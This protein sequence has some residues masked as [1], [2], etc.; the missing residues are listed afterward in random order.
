MGIERTEEKS[1]GFEEDR[2]PAMPWQSGLKTLTASSEPWER[3][4]SLKAT[5]L[6]PVVI[7]H[8]SVTPTRLP[9]IRGF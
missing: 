1:L 9:Y 2:V 5:R 8:A 3:A 6:L 4:E 7:S